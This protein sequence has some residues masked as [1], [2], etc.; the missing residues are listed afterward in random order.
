MWISDISI[1]RPVFATM[2]IMSFMV[3]GLVSMTRLGIDLFPD[4]NFPFVNVSVTYPGA[5]PEEVADAAIVRVA[6]SSLPIMT[7]AVGSSQRSAITRREVED[8]LKRLLE[9]IDGVAA[10]EVNGGNVRELQAG[11]EPRRLGARGLPVSAV[12]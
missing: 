3:L 10:V 7:F 11:L 1:K 8:G 6:V 4:V 2:I 12:A 9:Q 5:S